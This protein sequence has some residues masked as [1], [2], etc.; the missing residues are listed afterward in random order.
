MGISPA[1]RSRIIP[2]PIPDTMPS[3]ARHHRV[4]PIVKRLL[5]A[6]DGE[7]GK[8][9][10][11]EEQDVAS[12]RLHDRVHVEGQQTAERCDGE[13]VPARDC[14]RRH[15]ADEHIAHDASSHCH[16]K[17]EHQHPEE[18]EPFWTASSPPL[19]ANTNEPSPSSVAVNAGDSAWNI[20]HLADQGGRQLTR[21]YAGLAIAPCRRRG[22]GGDGDVARASA[23]T[24]PP[25]A[26][27]RFAS[28]P[29]KDT[30]DPGTIDGA[31][32]YS[33]GMDALLTKLYRE[34]FGENL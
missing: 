26:T 19:R 9:D 3:T 17:G 23:E 33:V 25:R 14:G 24:Q 21:S 34:R 1:S 2:P 18:I 22:N 11:I 16:H 8:A 10:R 28:R 4:D 30:L 6:C 20:D 5:R 12:E 7:Y 27:G 32:Q 29:L 31:G 15:G 13:G